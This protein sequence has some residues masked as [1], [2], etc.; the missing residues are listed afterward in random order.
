MDSGGQRRKSSGGGGRLRVADSVL[1][2]CQ[3]DI[4]L[5]VPFVC[6]RHRITLNGHHSDACQKI[7]I[8]KLNSRGPTS[9]VVIKLNGPRGMSR[10]LLVIKNACERAKKVVG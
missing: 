10:R 9:G 4:T 5:N 8:I 1:D 7:I 6:F 3:V 2:Q